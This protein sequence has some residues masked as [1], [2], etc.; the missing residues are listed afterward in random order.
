[1]GCGRGGGGSKSKKY[2]QTHLQT[3]NPVQPHGGCVKISKAFSPQKEY[4]FKRHVF[5]QSIKNYLKTKNKLIHSKITS[6]ETSS[7]TYR[8]II[9]ATPRIFCIPL[10]LEGHR[11]VVTHH[12]R[13]HCKAILSWQIARFQTFGNWQATVFSRLYFR[14]L[15]VFCKLYCK[16]TRVLKNIQTM[17]HSDKH[18]LLQMELKTKEYSFSSPPPFTAVWF[19]TLGIPAKADQQLVGSIYRRSSA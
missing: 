14:I 3:I 15:M 10:C 17:S 6:F 4:N 5:W 11:N 16:W 2:A 1:V 9:R 13:I 12:A 18:E 7:A 8:R 19:M